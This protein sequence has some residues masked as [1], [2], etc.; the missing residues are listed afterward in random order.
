MRDACQGCYHNDGCGFFDDDHFKFNQIELFERNC[1]G[2]CCGEGAECNRR[3][4]EGC[5][6][7]EEEPIMG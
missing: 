6:N 4:G 1:V 3:T 5:G 2:C 7:Y